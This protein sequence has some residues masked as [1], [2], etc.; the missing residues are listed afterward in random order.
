MTELPDDATKLLALHS[1]GN[2]AATDRL[3]VI[4]Y[5]QLRALA[6]KHLHGER[7]DHTLTPTALVHEAYLRLVDNTRIDWKGRSH[8]LAMAA[9]TLRRVLVDYARVHGAEKRGADWK[10]ITLTGSVAEIRQSELDL[11]ELDEVLERLHELSSRQAD[12]VELR[13][14]G[15]LTIKETAEALGIAEET[16]KWSWRMAR[17][18]LLRELG[19][20]R[21]KKTD[22]DEPT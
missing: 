10:R 2:R 1:E 5:D 13:Y 7:A 8:F 19:D 22:D 15:G 6:E 9:K 17:S 21:A 14:F 20:E 18:W 12:V 11:L 3:M 16:V 4:V